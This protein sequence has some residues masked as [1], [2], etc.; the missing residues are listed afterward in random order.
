MGRLLN[1]SLAAL[2]MTGAAAAGS[3]GLIAQGAKVPDLAGDWAPDRTRGGFGQSL[4]I[5]D[6]GGRKRGNEHDIPYQPWAREKTMSEKTSTGPNSQFGDTTDPQVLY[7]EP[8][9]VPHIYLWPIK[10]KFI[11]TPEAVYILHELG[12]FYPR[13]VVEQQ[14]IPRI[15]IRSGGGTRSASTRT[16]TRWSWTRSASTTRRGSIRWAIRTP[17]S[18]I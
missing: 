13:R 12:P 17:S 5:S 10:T 4:S 18:C 6:M 11:Q 2:L 1:A 14:S 3:R 16:A 15:R 9:G 8:P 7:C